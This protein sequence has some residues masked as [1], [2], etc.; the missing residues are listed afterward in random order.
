MKWGNVSQRIWISFLCIVFLLFISSGY[1]LYSLYKVKNILNTIEN[2]VAT[3]KTTLS[4]NANL[5]KEIA[6]ELN[7]G[8]H[9]LKSGVEVIKLSTDRYIKIVFVISIIGLIAT[10]VGILNIKGILS[11]LKN[12]ISSLAESASKLKNVVTG[13]ENNVRE[14]TAK[15]SQIVSSVNLMNSSLEEITTNVTDVLNASV[16]TLDVAKEGENII[17]QTADEIKAIDAATESFR[18][19]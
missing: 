3:I 16:S 19:P 1:N 4:N 7:E 18:K 12:V 8:F 6:A 5:C 17:L 15:T 10:I 14:Q 11:T 9:D 13:F 2:N